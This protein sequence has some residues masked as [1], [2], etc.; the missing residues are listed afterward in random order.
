M[1]QVIRDVLLHPHAISHVRK[2]GYEINPVPQTWAELMEQAATLK[3]GPFNF[4][5]FVSRDTNGA[6]V[7]GFIYNK[8]DYEA[9]LTTPLDECHW[10]LS[11][12]FVLALEDATWD[13]E[14]P[15]VT[16]ELA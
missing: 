4:L 16:D 8:N 10:R 2:K 15:Q 9:E 5:M 11:Q 12:V 3:L 6:E 13:D 14:K 7:L 1:Q